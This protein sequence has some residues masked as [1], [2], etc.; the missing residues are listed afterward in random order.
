MYSS[1]VGLWSECLIKIKIPTQ[2]SYSMLIVM[3]DAFILRVLAD[4][5]AINEM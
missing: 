3:I 5:S 2:R 4:V 1:E